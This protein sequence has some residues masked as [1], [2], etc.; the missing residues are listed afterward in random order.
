[1]KYKFFLIIIFLAIGSFLLWSS[2]QGQIEEEKTA[3]V[4]EEENAVE[5]CSPCVATYYQCTSGCGGELQVQV[6]EECC[7]GGCSDWT[8]T[9]TCSP[10]QICNSSSLSCSCSGTCLETPKNPRYYNNPTYSDQPEKSLKILNN[11]KL[12]VKLDWDDILGWGK[13][14]GPQSYV[15]NIGNTNGSF[16]KTIKT[17]EFIPESCSLKSGAV[18][19]WQVSGCCSA[20]GQDCGSASNWSFNANSSPEL[21]S[22]A[23]P[24][25]A[26]ANGGTAAITPGSPLKIDWCDVK[27]ANSYRLRVFFEDERT[28][29]KTCSPILD[30]PFATGDKCESWLIDKERRN[31]DQ[32][33]KL[34]YSDF[35]DE[36]LDFFTK[37][38]T[39]DWEIKMC[40]DE[41]GG[42]EGECKDY[43]QRWSF[44]SSQQ[45]FKGVNLISPPNDQRGETPVG[46]PII[47]DWSVPSGMNS[48]WY[49][50]YSV[51]DGSVIK[52]SWTTVPQSEALNSSDLPINRLYKWK[53]KA[54]S[55]YFALECEDY[56]QEKYFR[57]AG[58]PPALEE[59]AAGA[60]SITIPVNLKWEDVPG[61]KTYI[62]KF[63]GGNLNL[64]KIETEKPEF[65]LGY[66]EYNIMQDTNYSWQVKT[67]AY[68]SYACGSF[69]PAQTFKTFHLPAPS[70]PSPENNGQLFTDEK[71]ISWASVQGAKAYQYQVRYVSLSEN[72]KD[73]T[74]P[75]SVGKN[76][77]AEPKT[78]QVNSDFAE[79][80]CLG[81]Y[82]WQAR[83]CLGI[84]CKQAGDWSNWTFSLVE[85]E[86]LRGLGGLIPCGQPHN[87]PAT[88]WNE[89]EPCELKHAFLLVKI[90]IDFFLI[91]IVPII[92]VVLTI[93]S[94]LIFYFSI[95]R[96]N[97]LAKIISLWKSAGI[98]IAIIAFAW[99]AVNIF[100]RLIGIIVK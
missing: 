5:E 53:V 47:L 58:R 34:L 94:A 29:Q 52:T 74:C 33:E 61:A 10:W 36:D 77:F 38:T 19:P 28:G 71:F 14:D 17:S 24:D 32:I 3:P 26:G 92:L 84:D 98:G 72:E 8:T 85:P 31:P 57:T 66:P 95:E 13:P 41:Y 44:T 97:I 25:W 91:R 70:A 55:D 65:S 7:G 90:I 64:E 30:N 76:I 96:A 73:E 49:Q 56:S 46:Y 63:Q 43:S 62:L 67:C 81:N 37:D 1:M 27:E 18:H 88:A 80:R 89:R 35:T 93:Y 78:I 23:D 59:P 99:A 20:S 2:A 82:Q 86:E 60:E 50:I 54:C 40:L 16:P 6:C 83:A 75:A 15:L 68:E 4:E 45:T 9:Q 21:V 100:L 69:S 87:N 22:P 11:I 48:F 79:L 12:P 51:T 39:Y 42:L